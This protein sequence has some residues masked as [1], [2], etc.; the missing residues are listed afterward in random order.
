MAQIHTTRVGEL[1]LLEVTARTEDGTCHHTTLPLT[2]DQANQLARM[3]VATVQG[4]D[5]LDAVL[6]R[7]LT[8]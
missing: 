2:E 5:S 6:A 1:V 7:I 3:I 8:A 4:P